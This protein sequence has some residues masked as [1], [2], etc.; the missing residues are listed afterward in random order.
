MNMEFSEDINALKR[1]RKTSWKFQQT[2]RTT[3]PG[4]NL[5]SFVSTIVSATPSPGVGSFT[6]GQ[7]VIFPDHLTAFFEQNS[8]A[9]ACKSGTTLTTASRNEAEGLLLAAFSDPLDFLF[10]PGKKPFVLYADHDQFTTF[11]AQ[12]RSNLNRITEPLLRN[13]FQQILDYQRRL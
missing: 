1:L 7:A 5:T 4:Q 9:Q 10:A 3:A 2:F 12:T 13:G 11:F 8:L 6:I